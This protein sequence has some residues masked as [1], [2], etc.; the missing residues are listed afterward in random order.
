MQYARGFARIWTICLVLVVTLIPA[1][2]V[3]GVR[4][5]WVMAICLFGFGCIGFV[6]FYKGAEDIWLEF[7][8]LRKETVT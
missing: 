4:E 6:G 2:V 7:D 3:A 8:K 5:H 1:G